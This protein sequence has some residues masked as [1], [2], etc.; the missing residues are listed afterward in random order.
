MFMYVHI[1]NRKFSCL[2]QFDESKV[3]EATSPVLL[4]KDIKNDV[5]ALGMRSSHVR[6]AVALCQ[7]LALIEKEV[8]ED[9]FTNSF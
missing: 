9:I 8:R 4:M 7:T 5:E 1:Y 6:D 3:I 2:F